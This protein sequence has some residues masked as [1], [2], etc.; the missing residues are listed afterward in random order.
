MA[1]T[2][3]NGDTFLYPEDSDVALT[4]VPS[5]A[6]TIEEATR[7]ILAA[8]GTGV[9]PRFLPISPRPGL[10]RYA[11]VV[12]RDADGEILTTLALEIPPRVESFEY[13]GVTLCE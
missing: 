6:E 4:P 8:Y 10:R 11:A 9:T 1:L 13:A 5:M 7:E 2:Y 3:A 12:E